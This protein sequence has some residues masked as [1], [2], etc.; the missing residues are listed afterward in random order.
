[1]HREIKFTGGK[2]MIIAKKIKRKALALMSVV[3]L[4]AGSMSVFAAT[5]D[6]AD[7]KVPVL[8]NDA[9]DEG[10]LCDDG[11]IEYTEYPDSDDAPDSE[12]YIGTI[13]VPDS[14]GSISNWTITNG[15]SATSGKFYSYSGGSI[16]ISVAIVPSNKTVRVGI[17][18]PDGVKR[19]VEGNGS[20]G[21]SFSVTQTGYHKVYIANDSGTT[22]TA[23]GVYSY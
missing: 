15:H 7:G 3:C 9:G 20:V 8:R 6:E 14:N 16:T 4:F 11:Y 23:N 18:Q 1:M 2:S 12:I 22:V 19:Y 13:Y 5:S 10:V 21:H 17:V